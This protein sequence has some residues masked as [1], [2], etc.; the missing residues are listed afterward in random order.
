M[1]QYIRKLTT[2]IFKNIFKLLMQGYEEHEKS[3]SHI[4][5]INIYVFNISEE[6]LNRKYKFQ[7][8]KLKWK[9]QIK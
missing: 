1:K 7:T 9:K 6:K 5:G 2:L 8:W 3:N 4:I